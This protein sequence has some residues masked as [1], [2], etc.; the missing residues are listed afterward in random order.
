MCNLNALIVRIAD[1]QQPVDS[2]RSLWW[3][4]V[5]LLFVVAHALLVPEQQRLGARMVQVRGS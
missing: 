3:S 1:W 5:A 4:V 2:P